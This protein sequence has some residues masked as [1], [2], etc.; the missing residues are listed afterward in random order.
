MAAPAQGCIFGRYLFIDADGNV[1]PCT[2]AD[3]RVG[4]VRASSLASLWEALAVDPRVA[5]ARDRPAAKGNCATCPDLARCGGCRVVSAAAS[6]GDFTAADPNC[7]RNWG[8]EG[9]V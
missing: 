5:P 8:M 2:F 4:S 9:L 6:G 7:P 1:A 3:F